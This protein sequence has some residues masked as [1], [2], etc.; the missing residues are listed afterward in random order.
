MGFRLPVAFMLAADGGVN[1]VC[2][3]LDELEG[4]DIPGGVPGVGSDKAS[5][6]FFRTLTGPVDE[7][8]DW[9]DFGQLAK[10][11]AH[12]LY[13]VPS[14]PILCDDALEDQLSMHEAFHAIG[15]EPPEEWLCFCPY[16]I[17]PP[18]PSS[19]TP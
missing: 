14:P 1:P 6:I 16:C 4:C 19:P 17:D 15:Y 18:P 2:S 12:H 5:A 11:A 9:N 10:M 3:R 13:A 8:T 7:T